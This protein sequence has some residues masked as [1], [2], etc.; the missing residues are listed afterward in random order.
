MKRPVMA[1]EAK[2]E[3]AQ[4]TIKTVCV[5][6]RQMSLAIYKQLPGSSDFLYVGP[7]SDG[8]LRCWLEGKVWGR[9]ACMHNCPWR[10]QHL[11]VLWQKQGGGPLFRGYM[12]RE[13]WFDYR[14]EAGFIHAI[15]RDSWYECYDEIKALD[16]LFVGA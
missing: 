12:P 3:L 1:H 9:V 11:H 4:A 7:D 2:I 10:S 16:Q 8:T 15:F 5:G 6:P 14:E 13:G